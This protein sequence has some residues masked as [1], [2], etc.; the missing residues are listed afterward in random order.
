LRDMQRRWMEEDLC[1]GVVEEVSGYFAPTTI[2]C[3]DTSRRC[4]RVPRSLSRRLVGEV[5]L[6]SSLTSTTGSHSSMA[7]GM[8][9]IFCHVLCSC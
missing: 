4:H 7:R 9:L 8:T 1:V 6:G 3:G 5:I 2:A